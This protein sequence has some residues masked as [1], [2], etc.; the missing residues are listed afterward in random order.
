M[1][2]NIGAGHKIKEGYLGIDLY[3]AKAVD[4]ICDISKV[5]PFKDNSMEEIYMDNVIEHILDI[6]SL[7]SEL[8]RIGK[9]NAKMTII[10]PHFTSL[11]SWKDPSHYHHLSY[12]SF[13]HFEKTSTKHYIGK[14]IK[15]KARKL[16]FSGGLMGLVGRFLFYINPETYEKKF[17]F[18]FRASTLTFEL[19][20]V[21]K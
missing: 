2:L 10:T 16:S 6:P 8:V 15:L 9:N 14:G 11:S 18:M 7:I 1:K 17:C 12:F 21:K 5:L 4:L 3:K 20:V 13:D 19:E